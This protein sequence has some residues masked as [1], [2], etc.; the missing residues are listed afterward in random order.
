MLNK[1]KLIGAALSVIIAMAAGSASAVSFYDPDPDSPGGCLASD[2]W[3]TDYSNNSVEFFVPAL[4][5]GDGVT[6]WGNVY[7]QNGQIMG[8]ATGTFSCLDGTLYYYG[9]YDYDYNWV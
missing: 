2:Y 3:G 4:A 5:H 6:V 8:S 1:S 7:N 9:G